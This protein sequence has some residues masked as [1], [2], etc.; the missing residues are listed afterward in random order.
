[1]VASSVERMAAQ[2][3][4]WLEFFAG[5][6]ACTTEMRKAG[7]IGA[8]FDQLYCKDPSEYGRKSNWMDLTTPAG[9][10]FPS[11]KTIKKVY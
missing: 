8:K 10:A 7:F 1:M 4:Q 9:F 3:L 5:H 6:A 11:C 2:D